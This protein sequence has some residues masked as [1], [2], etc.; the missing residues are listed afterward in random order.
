MNSEKDH[1]KHKAPH[2]KYVLKNNQDN[3]LINSETETIYFDNNNNKNQAGQTDSNNQSKGI[4][5]PEKSDLKES[6]QQR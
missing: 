6:R 1:P 3:D 5:V 2:Q 4:N